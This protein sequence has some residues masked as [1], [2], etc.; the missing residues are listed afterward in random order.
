[1]GLIG[2]ALVTVGAGIM[3]FGGGIV[4]GMVGGPGLAIAYMAETAPNAMI[5]IGVAASIPSP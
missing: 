2:A 3:V 1:M 5:A 4:V